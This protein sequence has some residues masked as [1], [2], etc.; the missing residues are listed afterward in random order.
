MAARKAPAK[1]GGRKKRERKTSAG[2]GEAG[3]AKFPYTTKPGSLRKFLEMVPKKPRPDKVNATLLKSWGLKDTNDTSIIRVLKALGL[4]SSDN[5]PT[6]SYTAFMSLDSGA[7]TL[8]R[9]VR[10][11]YDA[12]FPDLLGSVVQ[13][14][15]IQRQIDQYDPRLVPRCGASDLPHLISRPLIVFCR[16]D[17][18]HDRVTRENRAIEVAGRHRFVA[19]VSRK[20]MK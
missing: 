13:H 8:G 19:V 12:L 2:S 17:D 20:M 4:V 10:R 9:G 3:K 18:G 7:T 6:D 11:V 15:S 16:L 1:K 14:R 5:L